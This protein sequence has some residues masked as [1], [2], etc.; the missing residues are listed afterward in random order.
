LCLERVRLQFLLVA[1]V[2]TGDPNDEKV[3]KPGCNE[4]EEKEEVKE[5]VFPSY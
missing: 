1:T 2:A 3:T 4:P 5:V